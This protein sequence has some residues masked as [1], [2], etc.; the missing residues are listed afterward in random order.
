MSSWIIDLIVFNLLNITV[1]LGP[2]LGLIRI[3]N[4]V[5]TSHPQRQTTNQNGQKQLYAPLPSVIQ[6]EGDKG[7]NSTNHVFITGNLNTEKC[8]SPLFIFEE[9]TII[10]ISI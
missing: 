1:L 10:G 9:E 3:K 2:T 6:R 8:I 4:S 7:I 5:N